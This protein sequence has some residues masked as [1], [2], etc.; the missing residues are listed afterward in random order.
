[1]STDL[2]PE[3]RELFDRLIISAGALATVADNASV[4]LSEEYEDM[5][6][7]QID[8]VRHILSQCPTPSDTAEWDGELRDS[9]LEI[10]HY[11]VRR[12]DGSQ[13]VDPIAVEII[14]L[15]TGIGRKS[16][17]KPR[18]D[19]NHKVALKSLTDAVATEYKRRG[20]K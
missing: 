2:T 18:Q 20:G 12:S 14:H 9:D 17:S 7:P 16:E 4:I 3:Q 1:M 13:S 5:C 15:P 10:K 8:E 19:E 11:F 6:R